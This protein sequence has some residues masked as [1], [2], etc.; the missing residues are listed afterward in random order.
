MASIN[1]KSLHDR[2]MESEDWDEELSINEIGPR[3]V[4]MTDNIR[5]KTI[6]ELIA[7]TNVS[8]IHNGS[9][10]TMC[11]WESQYLP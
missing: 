11:H 1:L 2:I 9:L 3:M 5:I 7:G 8:T 10:A 4:K 6:V